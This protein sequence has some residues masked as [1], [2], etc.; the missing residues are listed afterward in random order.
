MNVDVRH[1]QYRVVR[2]RGKLGGSTDRILRLGQWFWTHRGE[3]VALTADR[4]R[5]LRNHGAC[6]HVSTQPKENARDLKH[7]EQF[8]ATLLAG[9]V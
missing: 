4:R 2:V 8:P 9:K 3:R 6:S 7:T 5:R 1:R